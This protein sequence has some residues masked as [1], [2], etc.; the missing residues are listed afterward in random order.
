[1]E[2]V[3]YF[4]NFAFADGLEAS[5]LLQYELKLPQKLYYPIESCYHKKGIIN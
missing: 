2:T 3:V 5:Q 1:M 4:A